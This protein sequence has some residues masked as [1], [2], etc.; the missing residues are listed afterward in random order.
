[1]KLSE[2]V[3]KLQK[4]TLV[5]TKQLKITTCVVKERLAAFSS[6]INIKILFTW[7]PATHRLHYYGR[8]QGEVLAPW[9]FIHG[10]NIVDRG[11]KLLF[12]GLFL[13]FCFFFRCPTHPSWK[14][15]CRRPCTLQCVSGLTYVADIHEDHSI[16]ASVVSIAVTHG[17]NHRGTKGV[18][19]FF[20]LARSNWRKK[21]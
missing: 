1:V 20:H 10:T 21:D 19:A 16:R 11:L 4:V 9:I 2:A 13:L 6:V 3:K 17:R 12:F 14:F 7:V 15:F 18:E 5:L 8:R